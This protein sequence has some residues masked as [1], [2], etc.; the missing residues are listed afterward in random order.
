MID[1]RQQPGDVS[2]RLGGQQAIVGQFIKLC[3]SRQ[4]VNH[5]RQPHP[6]LERAPRQLDDALRSGASSRQVYDAV[7][8][9]DTDPASPAGDE[10]LD[11]LH[12]RRLLEAGAVI[13]D[14]IRSAS[15]SATGWTIANRVPATTSRD[16]PCQLASHDVAA[17]IAKVG[18]RRE[19]DV[20][21]RGKM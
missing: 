15:S 12:D 9:K 20:R 14:L 19:L 11:E 5:H 10:E 13:V 8:S 21:G 16:V 4:L 17:A 18:N 6:A 7:T 2:L 3:R 1:R